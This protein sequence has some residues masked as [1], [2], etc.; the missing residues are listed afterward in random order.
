[1]LAAGASVRGATGPQSPECHRRYR[2]VDAH[3]HLFN[4]ELQGKDGIPNYVDADATVE[5]ALMAMDRG[6]VDTAFLISYDADDIAVQ[7]RQQGVDPMSLAPVMSKEY[8]VSAWQAHKD[9]FWWFTD[10]INPL[11]ETCLEDLVRDFERGA[12][13]AKLLPWFCGLLADHPG[14]VPVYE[15]CRKRGKPVILDL[16]WW[17]FDYHPLFNEAPSRKELVKSSADYARLLEPVFKEFATVP[18]SLAHCGAAKTSE[19]YEDIFGLIASH[20][21]V[22][23]DVAAAADYSPEFI[24]KLVR[25]VGAQKVMYGTDWPYWSCG[26]EGY[27]SGKRCWTMI[28]DECSSLSEKEKQLILAENAERFVHSELPSEDHRQQACNDIEKRARAVHQRSTVLV[29]HDHHPIAEDVPLMLA[30]GVTAKVYQ[31]DVD[32]E[33]GADYM[34]SAP[35]RQGWTRRAR[36]VLDEALQVIAADARLLLALTAEDIESAKREGRVAILLGVE[37][38]KLLE[39]SLDNLSLFHELGLRELQLSWAVPNQLVDTDGLTAFGKGVIGEAERLGII[40]DIDHTQHVSPK[41]FC[42]ALAA[43]RKP[44]VV[45]HCAAKALHAGLDDEQIGAVARNGGVI[46]VHFYSSMIGANPTVSRVADHID[47]IA[48]RVGVE[49]VG[50]GVDFFPTEGK[51][52]DFQLAQGTADI[53]WAIQDLGHMEE[54]T[55]ELVTRSYSNRQ[56]EGILGANFLRVCREAFGR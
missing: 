50:L 1:M 44:V 33:I 46:G 43:A 36:M 28:A 32:V 56:I 4:T 23:C 8:Q 45:S 17:Y 12:T 18:F 20:P 5:A 22:S 40:V 39:G 6:G 55:Y 49:H 35:V 48:Q 15:L 3:V 25:A 16:S 21:N 19:D 2:V 53:S 10:H 29:M 52:R 11:R 30:G 27:L 51:W 13:G 26:S 38:G 42:E 24:E 14:F 47:Y 31:I 37:G 54:V 9:R 7:I 34:A 41:A